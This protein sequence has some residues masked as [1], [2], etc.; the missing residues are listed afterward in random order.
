MQF[1]DTY[2]D[3]TV[4][5]RKVILIIKISDMVLC[6]PDTCNGSHHT[7]IRDSAQYQK[8]IQLQIIL[9]YVLLI[10]QY[11]WNCS[12][13]R[14]SAHWGMKSMAEWKTAVTPVC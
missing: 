2:I 1:A 8:K 6:I 4:F 5:Y 13:K 7:C 11:Y 14:F 9:N 3:L 12:V 10:R